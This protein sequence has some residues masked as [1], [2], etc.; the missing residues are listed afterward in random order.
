[1]LKKTINTIIIES[2]NHC[3]NANES[4]LNHMKLAFKISLNLLQASLM[5]IVH[6]I[7]PALFQTSA[8]KKIIKLYEY[9]NS[10]K[11]LN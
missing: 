1:M 9:L 7:I 8:S 3:I 4:Y 6:A 11:R 5:A 2:K 10:K